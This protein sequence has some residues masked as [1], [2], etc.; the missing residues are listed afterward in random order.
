MNDVRDPGI[1]FWKGL[2]VSGL[3]VYHAEKSPNIDIID[4]Y[5]NNNFP[6]T[7][8]TTTTKYG[9]SLELHITLARV[10]CFAQE[11]NAINDSRKML[12]L[13]P[14]NLKPSPLTIQ[15]QHLSSCIETFFHFP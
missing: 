2:H 11:R 3:N 9:Y 1:L 4:H 10:E 7:F 13:R 12:K 5:F 8:E 14:L 15:R 6:S